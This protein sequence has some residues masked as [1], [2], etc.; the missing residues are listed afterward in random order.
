MA[1]MT[2]L[3]LLGMRFIVYKNELSKTFKRKLIKIRE[4]FEKNAE[5]V[6]RNILITGANSGLGF[7]LLNLLRHKNNIL[8]LTNQNQSNI[9]ELQDKK[10]QIINI[11]LELREFSNEVKEKIIN[12]R[13]NIVI[14]SAAIFG[15]ENQAIHDINFK[16]LEKI[17]NVNVFSTI[18]LI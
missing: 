4:Y 2:E 7:A 13:P 17:L 1:I 15:P 14:N 18:E 11:N 16:E 10:I 8:A 12:F 6:N 3:Q 5:V 9:R